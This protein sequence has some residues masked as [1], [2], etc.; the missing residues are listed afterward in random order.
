MKNKISALKYSATACIMLMLS[1]AACD[2]G[3]SDHQKGLDEMDTGN[4]ENAVELF[5]SSI[6]KEKELVSAYNHRGLSYLY[7]GDFDRSIFDFSKALELEEDA[8]IYYNRALAYK[9]K[10][11]TGN[12]FADLE[13][14][15][16]LNQTDMELFISTG[17]AMFELGYFTEA[18]NIF[19]RAINV[20]PMST[21]AYNSRGNARMELGDTEGAENDWN[22]A[23]EISTS[24][25]NIE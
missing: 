24:S 1:A 15:G 11:S 17:N 16:K 2:I 9:E 19:T 18:E 20:D 8:V 21:E 3:R 23:I 6:E 14:S 12:A 13:M 4:L 22:R 7:L 5:T 10:G 25:R